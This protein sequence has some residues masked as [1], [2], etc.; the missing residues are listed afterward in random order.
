MSRRFLSIGECMVELSQAGDGLLR[1]GFAGDTFNTAW[2]ARAC[3]AADWSVDYFTALGDDAMSDEMLAFINTSGIGTSLIRR[4]K[5]RTPG[6]YMINLKNGERSFS[7]WRD[8]SAARSLAAD[9]DSLRE[10]VESAAVIYFSGITLAILP[11]EDAETLLAE[12]RRAKAAG[13]LVVFD[14]NIRPRLWSSY[15]VMHT[16]ISEG[17]RSSVVVMPSFDDE[18]AHFGDDSIEATIHRYR[19]LGAVDIVVKNGADGVT[20]NFA[21]E[22]TFVPAEK[23]KK[24]VDTTS[25]GDSFNGAFLAR[26]LEAGDA[27]AAARFAAKV[28]AR[29]VSEHGALVVKEKLGLD[30][31]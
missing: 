14:P 9:P 19:A 8:S 23:V 4:I 26:Y 15:D 25:A 5:G 10:A 22:Q 24:V 11:H 1:K 13:K 31:G 29:V 6:L 16:T 7:Y 17:A 12:V 21:G 18:A 20:L 3:L 30:G 2:Y 27:P 28:A